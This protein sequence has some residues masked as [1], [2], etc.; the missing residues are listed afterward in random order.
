MSESSADSPISQP[1]TTGLTGYLAAEG[2]ED[3][4][5]TELA[6]DGLGDVVQ[7]HGRLMLAP[8]PVRAAAWAANVWHDVLRIPIAS[9]GEGA[10]ALRA[11]QRNWALYSV[12]HHRRAKLIVDRLPVVTAKP[13]VFPQPAPAAPLGSWTL[14]DEATILAAG[15]CSSPFPNGEAK[16]VEDRVGPPNRAYL[17]L[18]EALTQIR[19]YPQPGERCLD[20]GACPGGWTWVLQ[21]LGAHVVAVDKAP[22]DPKIAA[23]PNVTIRA[24]SAFGLKPADVGAVD[25][26]FSDVICYP[27]RLY[28][29]VTAWIESGLARNMVCTVKFQGDT[30]FEALRLFAAIPGARLLH[31]HHNKHELTWVWLAS[32][33]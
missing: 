4:L 2:F 20:L 28:R 24:E 13:L 3:D 29:L 11:I 1:E 19:R 12:S 5:R 15:H 17:K 8:G 14:L 10:K 6:Q 9:I 26:L 21:G 7:E 32:E 31:L 16:F 18:W 30:D 33:E 23:L 22:L 25:W 27:E